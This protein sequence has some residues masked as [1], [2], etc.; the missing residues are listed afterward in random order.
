MY[1][2]GYGSPVL[3]P[4]AEAAVLASKSKGKASSSP[5]DSRGIRTGVRKAK[6]AA[7]EAITAMAADTSDGYKGGGS[8]AGGSRSRPAKKRR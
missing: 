7:S 1:R 6:T 2:F 8:S 5:D 3:G 4:K